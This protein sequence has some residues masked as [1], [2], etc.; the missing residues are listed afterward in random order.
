MWYGAGP[1]AGIALITAARSLALLQKSETVRW[2][3]IRRLAKPVLR[4]RLRLSAHAAR[5]GMTEDQMI[6]SLLE[7]VLASKSNLALGLDSP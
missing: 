2:S 6:E 7:R 1:R 5:D 3:H 4:H